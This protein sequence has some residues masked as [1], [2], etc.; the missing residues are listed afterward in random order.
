MVLDDDEPAQA[1]PTLTPVP[2]IQDPVIKAQKIRDAVKRV[3]LN[4]FLPYVLI[5]MFILFFYSSQFAEKRPEVCFLEYYAIPNITICP[6]F[7]RIQKLASAA[8]KAK[9]DHLNADPTTAGN[10]RLHIF[11]LLFLDLIYFCLRQRY[12]FDF[13]LAGQRCSGHPWLGCQYH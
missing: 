3:S 12:K 13:D 5:L 4:V 9:L 6:Q 7:L 1:S 11:C 8:K 10:Y 2:V